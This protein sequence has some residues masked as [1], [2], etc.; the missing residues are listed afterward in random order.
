MFG[1]P[2]DTAGGEHR[3]CRERDDRSGVP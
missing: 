2:A 3:V 1:T